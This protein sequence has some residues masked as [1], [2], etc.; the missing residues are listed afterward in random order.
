MNGKRK[1]HKATGPA[2]DTGQEWVATGGKIRCWIVSVKKYPGAGVDDTH[3]SSYGVTYRYADGATSE[4]DAWN[5]Q[6]R[7][8][9]IADT[10]L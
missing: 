7:Y 4:K 6:V 9:H 5:F 1:W 2:F 10:G 8:E 3:T